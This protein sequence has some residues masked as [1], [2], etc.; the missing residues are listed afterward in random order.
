LLARLERFWLAPRPIAALVGARILLATVLCVAYLQRAPMALDLFGPAG[1]GGGDLYARVPDLV[2]FHPAIAAP[3]DL[4]RHAS[5]RVVAVAYGALL[6]SL[7]AFALGWHTRVAGLLAVVLHV[8]FWVRNPLAYTGWAAFVIG[9]LAYV[10]CAPVGRRLSVDAWLRRRRGL[11]PLPAVAP[12]WPLRLLQIH[13]AALYAHAGWS[14]LD[15]P[16]WLDG[17]LVE[18]ALTAALSSRFAFDWSAVAPLLRIATWASLLLEGLAPFLLWVPR[19][20]VVW[21]A[22]VA[23]FHV[24]LALVLHMEVWAWSGVMLAGLLAFVLPD[25]VV[26]ARDDRISP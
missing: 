22:L 23:V 16:D 8:L 21:A 18:I 2:P 14:R 15:K 9:P 25:D 13:V 6:A 10:A 17:S 4:L 19:V 7:A 24:G 5:E 3:L 12:G 11:P 1:I 20:R 26:A